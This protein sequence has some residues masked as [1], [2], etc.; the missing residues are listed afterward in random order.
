MPL[1]GYF[2]RMVVSLTGYSVRKKF[3]TAISYF[4]I[5]PFSRHIPK[6]NFLLS[7]LFGRDAACFR[8]NL[9]SR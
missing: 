6:F 9:K 1:T 4:K 8:T 3:R 2:V 7:V 5:V